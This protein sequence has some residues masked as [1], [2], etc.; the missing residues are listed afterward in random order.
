[1]SCVFEDNHYLTETE[2]GLLQGIPAGR[3]G[4]KNRPGEFP[5]GITTTGLRTFHLRH[6]EFGPLDRA[7]N[8]SKR[9]HVYRLGLLTIHGEDYLHE[10]SLYNDFP[11]QSTRQ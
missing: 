5:G 11:R 6:F 8:K 1:M 4:F 10:S 2:A 9:V 3:T 7:F